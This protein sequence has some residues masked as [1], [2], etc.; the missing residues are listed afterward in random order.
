MDEAANGR[1][2]QHVWCSQN[3]HRNEPASARTCYFARND[4]DVPIVSRMLE[5]SLPAAA[6]HCPDAVHAH[7]GLRPLHG[8][9]QLLH[10]IANEAMSPL[11]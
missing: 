3:A 1:S 10:E 8:A 4:G 9:D 6:V 5:L 2:L 11:H 7:Q